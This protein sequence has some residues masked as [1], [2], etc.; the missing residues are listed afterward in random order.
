[1]PNPDGQSDSWW[2]FKVRDDDSTIAEKEF[3]LLRRPRLLIRRVLTES[4]EAPAVSWNLNEIEG[5]GAQTTQQVSM[6]PDMVI[7]GVSV[8]HMVE[9]AKFETYV[10]SA[11][12]SWTGAVEITDCIDPASLGG[13]MFITTARAEDHRHLVLVQSPTYNALLGGFVKQ[14]NVVYMS[15]NGFKVWGGG[16]QKWYS[17]ILLQSA[18]ASIQDPPSEDRIGYILE[19]PAG[20]FP[21]LAIN[22]PVTDEELHTLVDSLIPTK[23]YLKSQPPQRQE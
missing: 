12:P 8:Q 20:T 7:P 19:S 22:G 9:R 3:V 18:R 16:P 23:E 2:L 17:Q 6:T 10:F 1:M 15:P 21:A 11:K 5:T 14:G 13:R 4:V